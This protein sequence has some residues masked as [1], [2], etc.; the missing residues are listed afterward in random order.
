MTTSTTT[1]SATV[2]PIAIAVPI[3]IAATTTPS[4]TPTITIAST[5]TSTQ[6][7]TNFSINNFGSNLYGVQLGVSNLPTGSKATLVSNVSG[8]TANTSSQDQA[9]STVT[10]DMTLSNPLPTPFTTPVETLTIN[11]G[12]IT[13][14]LVLSNFTLT[15]KNSSGNFVDLN[16]MNT[17]YNINI[18]GNVGYTVS[19][20]NASSNYTGGTGLNTLVFSDTY[21]KYSVSPLGN[22]N[23][24][25][26]YSVNGAVDSVQSFQRLKFKDIGLAYDLNGSAGQVAKILGAIYGSSAVSNSTYAG[27]GLNYL[28]QGMSYQNLISLA[29]NNKLGTGFTNAAE[30]SLLFQ[31]LANTSPSA[32]D[33]NT[34]T[35]LIANGTYTQTSLAQFACDNALNTNNINLT[36]LVQKGLQFV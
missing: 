3:S 35:N 26:S 16:L 28:N 4:A 19:A 6:T 25:V 20:N 10:L 7:V 12:N 31:N 34:W 1:P 29:L 13:A 9:I 18:T 2:T 15:A 23:F 22:N 11:Q 14:P 8:W 30:V 21:N 32:Q 17:A 36:G 33:L 5:S 24:T 27:I